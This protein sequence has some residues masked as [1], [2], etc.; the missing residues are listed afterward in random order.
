MR[1]VV[2]TVTAIRFALSP[3]RDLVLELL[4]LHHQVAVLARSNRRFRS[5]DRLLW[6]ILRRVWPQWR[7]ALVLVQPTT[8]DRW[9]RDRFD[10][11]W[12]RRS[13]RP[14]R[15]RI[16]SPCRDLIRRLAEENRLWGA[17][18]IHGEMLKLGL[19]VSERSVS[20]HLREWPRRPSQTWRTFLANHLGQFTFISPMMS[21]YASGDDVI[22]ASAVT[23][24]STPL[25][26][27]LSAPSQCVLVDWRASGR[28]TFVG[29]C[30]AQ[31]HCRDRTGMRRST[32]RAP[33][34]NVGV[35][36][37]HGVRAAGRF[38]TLAPVELQSSTA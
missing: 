35:Q 32:S 3:R 14:G 28:R 2:A 12:W 24:R 36:P 16:D 10:R 38:V 27:R 7:D 22:D 18:R 30:M 6:L 5:S 8:V 15:P 25:A 37:T 1:Q 29:S 33:P 17:P 34:K 26:D 9:H 19:V 23:S 21:P 4:A 20:R 11:R 13:R 31:D